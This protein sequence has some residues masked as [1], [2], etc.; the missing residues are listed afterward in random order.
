MGS[1]GLNRQGSL[2]SKEKKN[3]VKIKTF[4]TLKKP[5]SPAK[6]SAKMAIFQSKMTLKI[7]FFKIFQ[8]FSQILFSTPKKTKSRSFNS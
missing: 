1:P 3:A 2:S 8:T 7:P 4:F 6:K 5:H